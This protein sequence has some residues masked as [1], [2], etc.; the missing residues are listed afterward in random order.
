MMSALVVAALLAVPAL[1]FTLWPL[2]RRGSQEG[3]L[4]LP[5]DP[6]EQLL[7]EKRRAYGA[8]RE[9]AFERDAGHLSDDDYAA[10]RARYEAHAARILKGLDDLGPA[11]EALPP[12][13]PLQAVGPQTSRR[14]PWTRRPIAIGAGSVLLVIFG[15]ALGLGAARYSEPDPTGGGPVPGTR[16]LAPAL[17]P[18]AAGGPAG[19]G[20]GPLGDGLESGATSGAPAATSPGPL[21][22]EMLQGMLQAARTSLFEGRYTEAIA[23]YQAV[24]KRDPQNVDALTHLGLIVALGGHADVALDTLDRALAIDPDYP[25]ALLYRGQVLYELKQ[26]YRAAL[27]SWEKFLARVPRGA[28]HERVAALVMEARRR[29]GSPV[30]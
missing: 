24:L 8:L 22:P 27:T 5:P 15:I 30:P 25:A 11:P 7:E 2:C 28:E 1:A 6:R 17:G 9:L 18:G 10:L 14:L 3:L 23:A 16:P 12:A 19:A 29:A 20:R 21:P 13:V 4:P 26:D